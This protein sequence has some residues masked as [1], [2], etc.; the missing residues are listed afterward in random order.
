MKYPLLMVH[1]MG[2]RDDCA[3]GYWGR[4]PEAL[5]K[6]GCQVFFGNQ[7]SN[8]DTPTNA[9]VLKDRILEILEETGAE[10]VNILAHSK[11]GLESR[12]AISQLGVG[13]KVA[14][15]TTIDTPHHGS[16]TIDFLMKLPDPVLRFAGFCGDCWGRLIGDRNPRTY[17]VVC[18][19]ST[20]AAEEF[21]RVV[22]DDDRVYYQSYACVMNGPGSDWIMAIP[23]ILVGILEGPNDGFLP[24]ARVKW[25]SFRGVYR[26]KGRRGV[27]H[28]DEIDL[29][30]RPMNRDQDILLFYRKIVCDLC[31]MGF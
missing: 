24:P 19:F 13:E 4:I 21:N 9:Q 25:G 31:K 30:R 3:F 8:A 28:N 23:N 20:A 5:R 6:M 11:G 10:K 12:Y 29:R 22:P 17:D 1:G 7:E 2:F 16:G 15:L 18:G 26:G 27:S 14:S